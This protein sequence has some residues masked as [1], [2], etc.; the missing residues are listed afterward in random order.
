M[1]EV[2]PR[3]RKEP[4]QISLASLMKRPQWQM[5]Q[6]FLERQ[7][8]GMCKIQKERMIIGKEKWRALPYH[9]GSAVSHSEIG[10]QSDLCVTAVTTWKIVICLMKNHSKKKANSCLTKNCAMVA[11]L[12][13]YKTITHRIVKVEGNPR[14]VQKDTLPHCMGIN[15]KVRVQMTR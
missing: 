7:F 13:L 10:N 12:Q 3:H 5:T 6:C 8:R 9:F 4:K 2:R 15:K 11:Y 14:S 1:F